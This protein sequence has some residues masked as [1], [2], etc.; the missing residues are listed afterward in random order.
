MLIAPPIVL[1]R[2]G[3]YRTWRLYR[4]AGRHGT[5]QLVAMCH[6]HIKAWVPGR[7]PRWRINWFGD[8]REHSV[9]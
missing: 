2:L 1:H 6:A 5:L 4:Q 7:P 9:R 3:Q 8:Y